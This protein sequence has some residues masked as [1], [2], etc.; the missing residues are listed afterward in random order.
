MLSCHS[1]IVDPRE[2]WI[3]EDKL[4]QSKFNVQFIGIG[5]YK[6]TW[7]SSKIIGLDLP[8]MSV[9][10]IFSNFIFVLKNR[11][12]LS[13]EFLLTAL[14]S[15]PVAT[16]LCLIHPLF[17]FENSNILNYLDS[18]DSQTFSFLKQFKK[19]ASYL[20]DNKILGI[21]IRLPWK[22]HFI[23]IHRNRLILDYCESLSFIPDVIHANDFDTFIAAS[24]F[25]KKNNYRVIYDS[26]E[27]FPYSNPVFSALERRLYSRIDCNY[28]KIVDS[29][30]TVSTQLGQKMKVL[31]K[32]RSI[33]IIPNACPKTELSN[34][35]NFEPQRE[36]IKF[37]FQGNFSLNRG[38]EFILS[39]WANYQ[40]FSFADLYLIGP[41]S[42]HKQYLIEMSRNFEIL[43]NGVYFPESVSPFL[44]TQ[45]L[46]N[47]DV[48]IIPYPPIDLNFKFCC[49]NKLSQYMSAGLAILSNQ[50]PF[51]ND[52]IDKGR[53]GLHYCEDDPDSFKKALDIMIDLDQL[54]KFKEA[55]KEFHDSNFNWSN[56]NQKLLL[57]YD[58][59]EIFILDQDNDFFK[60]KL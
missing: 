58:N 5:S 60:F 48:G 12:F 21:I 32:L 18:K 46:L 45:N 54:A 44:L 22:I 33:Y 31:Y 53:I 57:I 14:I 51:V 39:C 15:L 30:I 38:L 50:L 20:I 28:C 42:R 47:Y 19:M 56:F 3:C 59:E 1:P 2:R 43:N 13:T 25:K 16:L 27:F 7:G 6:D 17:K 36:R 11:K 35:G 4:V 40:I 41:D 8:A 49:P 55:S 29:V 52:I 26:Q 23:I 10:L 37:V 34:Y 9:R 24:I